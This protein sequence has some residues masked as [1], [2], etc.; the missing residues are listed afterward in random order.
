LRR[1]GDLTGAIAAYETAIALNP[2]YTAAYNNL[3]RVLSDQNRTADA[4]NAFRQA[5]ALDP[6]NAVAYSNLGNLLRSQGN[7]DE[8]IDAFS[9]T[10]AIGKE[11]LWVDYTSLGLAYADRGRFG[12]AQNAY[13]KA[14]SLN[15]NFAKAHFGLG[16]LYTLKGE[17]SN[18][19]R[20]YQEALKLYEENRDAEWIKRTQQAI[21]SLQGIT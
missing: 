3:G 13:F 5:I 1:Q 17:V 19:I 10:I 11:D 6:R 21:Q 20:S 7:S 8:A 12:E 9:K 4:I 18:A 2:Q 15:P 16:A 14:L